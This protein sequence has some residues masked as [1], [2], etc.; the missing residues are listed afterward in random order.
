[1]NVS[2]LVLVIHFFHDNIQD[3][4]SVNLNI[5]GKPV[6]LVFP[7][8]PKFECP[9]DW[10]FDIAQEIK[11]DVIPLRSLQGVL[12]GHSLSKISLT[13]NGVLELH[14]GGIIVNPFVIPKEFLLQF[15]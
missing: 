15:R 9:C 5:H 6:H 1:M 2:C 8:K 7:S 12:E 10:I 11:F 3:L 14:Y 13:A 4:F